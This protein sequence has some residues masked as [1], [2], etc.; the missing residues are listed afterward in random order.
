LLLRHKT[1]SD[2]KYPLEAGEVA[3]LG[4]GNEGVEKTSLFGRIRRHPAA[5]RNVL[6]SARHQLPRVGLFKPKEVPDLTVWVVE[7]LSKDVGGSFRGRQPL[8]Q[9]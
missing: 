2:A 9:Q 7:R 4:R 6:A 5:I 8:Q 3:V 1:T